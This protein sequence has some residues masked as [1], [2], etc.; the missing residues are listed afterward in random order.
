MLKR[1]NTLAVWVA[2]QISKNTVVGD[3][4]PTAI[5]SIGDVE[6]FYPVSED[7]KTMS[8]KKT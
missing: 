5:I 8:F 7:G 2:E 6:S 1:S 4:E 3:A